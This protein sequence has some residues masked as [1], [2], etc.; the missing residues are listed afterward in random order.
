MQQLI[1]DVDD[2][3]GLLSADA[4]GSGAL[5]S[6]ERASSSTGPWA[7]GGT[8]P[9]VA[10]ETQY[11]IWDEIGTDA[12]WYR[13]RY[14]DAEGNVVSAYSD[15]FA[16]TVN[17]PGGLTVEQLRQHVTSSLPDAALQR[18]LDAAGQAITARAG[19]IGTISDTRVGGTGLLQLSR[20]ASAIVDVEEVYWLERFE[21]A[22][23]RALVFSEYVWASAVTLDPSDYDLA[24][25]GFWMQRMADGT[26]P[27]EIWGQAVRITYTAFDDTAERI[28]VQLELV[29]LDLASKPGVTSEQIGTW[30]EQYAPSGTY[31]EAR[32][33]ILRSLGP[34]SW[35]MA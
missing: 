14:T 7:A 5:L 25:S 31:A 18:L 15:P 28:R 2:P 16:G 17:A 19:N 10:T 32:E 11:T 12:T 35:R 22:D 13:S 9:L 8:A 21:P 29:K 20:R 26:N 30:T 33:A 4:F 24:A 3:A 27:A 34:R 6:W 23:L 1:I